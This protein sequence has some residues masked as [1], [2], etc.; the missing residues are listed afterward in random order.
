MQIPVRQRN[1]RRRGKVTTARMLSTECFSTI[2]CSRDDEALLSDCA[3]AAV[4]SG[5]EDYIETVRGSRL[6]VA[7]SGRAGV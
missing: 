7:R 4:V 3:E 5:G 6:Y 1:L 2:L